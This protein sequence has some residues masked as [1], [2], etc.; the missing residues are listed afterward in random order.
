MAAPAYAFD[1]ARS[2]FEKA[3][4]LLVDARRISEIADRIQ[5]TAI[6]N[7]LKNEVSRLIILAQQISELARSLP[8]ESERAFKKGY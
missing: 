1:V 8:G 4:E 5:D 7:E 3:D 6:G 2:L